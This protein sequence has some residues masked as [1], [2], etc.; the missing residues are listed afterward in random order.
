MLLDGLISDCG[1]LARMIADLTGAF[2]VA[3]L[4]E[5]YRVEGKKTLGFELAEDFDWNLPDAVVYPTGGGTGLIGMWKAFEELATLGFIRSA[6]P[7][8]DAVQ[9]GGA[10]PVVRAV[11]A[12]AAI[13]PPRSRALT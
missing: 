11:E 4:R 13:A 1:K 10:A 8:I 3:T 7:R 9:A 12:G 6:R 2:D 5:P